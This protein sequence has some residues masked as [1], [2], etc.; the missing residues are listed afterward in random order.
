MSSE[1]A[2]KLAHLSENNTPL[3]RAI[4]HLH[5]LGLLGKGLYGQSD[6]KFTKFLFNL[7]RIKRLSKYRN[8]LS[9]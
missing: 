7:N 6:M 2:E 9:I 8:K 5:D 3:A 4:R 1:L